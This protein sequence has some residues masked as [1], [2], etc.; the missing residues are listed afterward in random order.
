MAGPKDDDDVSGRGRGGR[1]GADSAERPGAYVHVAP[2]SN[3][4]RKAPSSRATAQGGGKVVEETDARGPAARPRPGP[5]GMETGSA[6]RA[7]V[8][9]HPRS[10]PPGRWG[11]AIEQAFSDVH[12]PRPSAAPYGRAHGRIREISEPL[13][14]GPNA[15]EDP[16]VG[17]EVAR[18]NGPSLPPWSPSAPTAAYSKPADALS[19]PADALSQPPVGERLSEPSVLDA[20]PGLQADSPVSTRTP[21]GLIALVAALSA[22]IAA[23]GV[24][25]LQEWMRGAPASRAAH[26]AAGVP[27]A[28]V[29]PVTPPPVATAK[30]QGAGATTPAAAPAVHVESATAPQRSATPVEPSAAT[31]QPGS[32]S[33]AKESS[34]PAS[35]TAP[36]GAGS[37]P[38]ST[39]TAPGLSP[40]AVA[41]RPTT[42]ATPAAERAPLP[43]AQRAPRPR[44][45]RS[46][47]ARERSAPAVDELPANPF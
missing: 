30:I 16:H 24:I 37:Q 47:E 46:V 2:H 18:S 5:M 42:V 44:K 15:S 14:N 4:R 11:P 41:T 36:A 19:Q 13:Q 20:P 35:G 6:T 23:A 31:A 7:E 3:R 1:A 8:K 32:V 29:A 39:A 43:P 28:R 10:E 25:A 12:A 22:I 9:P 26:A 34:A 27:A 21:W 45:V 40:P 17:A 38:A 33:A